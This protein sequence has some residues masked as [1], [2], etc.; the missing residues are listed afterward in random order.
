ML[1]QFPQLNQ[2]KYCA[3]LFPT[4]PYFYCRDVSDRIYTKKGNFPLTL[5][6]VVPHSRRFWHAFFLFSGKTVPLSHAL[7]LSQQRN[8][9]DRPTVEKQKNTYILPNCLIYVM[10]WLSRSSAWFNKYNFNKISVGKEW[11]TH[12]TI[13]RTV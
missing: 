4:F 7:H 8:H 2:P 11:H 5:S 3:T 10:Y 1:Y 9:K 6:T 13:T 12:I